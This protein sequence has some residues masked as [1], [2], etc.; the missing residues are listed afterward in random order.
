VDAFNEDRADV[1]TRARE[2]GVVTIISVG[3]DLQSSHEATRLAES[4]A[5]VWAAVGLHPHEAGG[6]SEPDMAHL[7]QLA[8]HPRVVAIG[9]VGL[10]FYRDYSPREE[11]LEALKWQLALAAELDLPVVIH[12]R[13]AEGQ[14]LPLLRDWTSRHKSSRREPRGVIHC[15]SGDIDTAR[16][17]LDMGFFISFGAYIGYPASRRKHGMIRSIPQ[18]RLVVETDSP[19]LPPQGHRG[20]RNEPAFL[21][22]TVELLA[23]I[24]GV[25]LEQIAQET[26][27]N[28]RRLFRLSGD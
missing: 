6:V 18:D 27:T 19:F 2:C 20:K 3:T 7:A 25:S 9:E 17:Y 23:E 11:Q 12:C 21:P 14:M 28:A 5:E 16:Q 4:H 15:F 13:Q 22:L 10:D 24:R 26:T 8:E 1:I